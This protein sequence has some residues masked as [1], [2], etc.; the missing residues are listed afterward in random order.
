MSGPNTS[1]AHHG[2]EPSQDRQHVLMTPERRGVDDRRASKT[3]ISPGLML[4][5][6]RSSRP[7]DA[8]INALETQLKAREAR[9]PSSRIIFRDDACGAGHPHR[10]RSL[11]SQRLADHRSSSN[12]TR[13]DCDNP[14]VT[15]G[16]AQ[17]NSST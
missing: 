7:H 11:A 13:I 3:T 6:R 16:D 2:H 1:Q 8:H 14:T 17:K 15:D 12:Q 4:S 9:R 10:A 5:I